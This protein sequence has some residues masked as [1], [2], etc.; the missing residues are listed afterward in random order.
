MTLR[1]LDPIA[2]VNPCWCEQSIPSAVQQ[3][4][5][6]LNPVKLSKLGPPHMLDLC[7]SCYL[8][9]IKTQL[10]GVAKSVEVTDKMVDIVTKFCDCHVSDDQV[11]MCKYDCMFIIK[12]MPLGINI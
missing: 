6:V 3:L 7:F 10:V 5:D 2:P 11:H 9:L 12:F 4:M 1:T 8:P